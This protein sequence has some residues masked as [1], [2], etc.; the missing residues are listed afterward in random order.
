MTPQVLLGALVASL[1][2]SNALAGEV[3]T[4]WMIEGDRG[5]SF[6]TGDD[7]L[8]DL[9]VGVGAG[10]L[11]LTLQARTFVPEGLGFAAIRGSIHANGLGPDDARGDFEPEFGAIGSVGPISGE[12]NAATFSVFQILA[13]GPSETGPTDHASR[14]QGQFIDLLSFE[15]TF[16]AS[17]GETF[18]FRYDPTQTSGDVASARIIEAWGSTPEPD[19]LPGMSIFGPTTRIGFANASSVTITVPV[20]GAAL[21]G[22]LALALLGARRRR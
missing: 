10:S 3:E 4:R 7:T 15:F 14:G 11:R 16:G 22:G 12:P 13:V 21:P 6:A 17:L 2:A 9:T 1:S 19:P 5:T 8:S 18:T 20:P